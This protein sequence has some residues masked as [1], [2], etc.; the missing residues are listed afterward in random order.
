MACK[1]RRGARGVTLIES[2]FALTLLGLA[3]TAIGNLFVQQIR[4]QGWNVYRTNA[5]ALASAALEDLRAMD[6][7]S[8][9]TG[10]SST[11][12][13]TATAT[14][15]GMTYTVNTYV[16]ADTPANGM[17]QIT[18]TVSFRDPTGAQSYSLNGI[19]TAIKR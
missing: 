11:P 17:K 2:L 10:S 18:V 1:F 16:L 15:G 19:Y 7:A 3:A 4:M 12:A 8:I 14:L 9:P 5:I 13:R 6:Y